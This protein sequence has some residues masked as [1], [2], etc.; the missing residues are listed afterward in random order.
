MMI[1][2]YNRY[3][4]GLSRM[5]KFNYKTIG[6]ELFIIF[7][8]ATIWFYFSGIFAFLSVFCGGLCWMIPNTYFIYRSR[9]I[10]H[11]KNAKNMLRDFLV[12][13]VLKLVISAVLIV[14]SIKFFTKIMVLQFLNGYIIAVF[15]GLFPKDSRSR[16]L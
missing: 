4:V 10:A 8:F 5:L 14:I 15:M 6:I 2:Y 3:I 12:S 7:V 11:P 16:G 1:A 9:A 13:E